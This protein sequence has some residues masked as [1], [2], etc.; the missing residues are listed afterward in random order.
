MQEGEISDDV[1]PCS[2]H[3]V[4]DAEFPVVTSDGNK[5]NTERASI[6]S[7]ILMFMGISVAAYVGVFIR[8]GVSFYK[9]W[10]IESNYVSE[11]T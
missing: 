7:T 10:K 5:D 2:Y 6:T 1:V 8:I 4:A 9:I 3:T 11:N